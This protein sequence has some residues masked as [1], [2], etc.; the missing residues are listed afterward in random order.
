MELD[1]KR[2]ISWFFLYILNGTNPKFG[3]IKSL[4]APDLIFMVVRQR[5]RVPTYKYITT[6]P[7]SGY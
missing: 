3:S 1:M 6:I 4:I 7:L 2:E 5:I